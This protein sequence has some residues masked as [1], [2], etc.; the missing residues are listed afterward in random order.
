MKKLLFGLSVLSVLAV[1]ANSLNNISR[2]DL[3]FDLKYRKLTCYSEYM[4][5]VDGVVK[6]VKR[7]HK[8]DEV[9]WEH[10]LRAD[11]VTDVTMSGSTITVDFLAGDAESEWLDELKLTLNEDQ[12]KIKEVIATKNGET[13]Y[14]CNN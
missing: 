2:E 11:V 10:E 1:N 5:E 13:L 12:T 8:E 4:A 7:Y 9:D 14:T 6:K 3:V